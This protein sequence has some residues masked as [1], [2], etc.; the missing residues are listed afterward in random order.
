MK[1]M[2]QLDV[3]PYLS[4]IKSCLKHFGDFAPNDYIKPVEVDEELVNDFK[5]SHNRRETCRRYNISPA[6][7]YRIYNKYLEGR[8]KPDKPPRIRKKQ[9]SGPISI[10]QIQTGSWW[11]SM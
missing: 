9:P 11:R 7:A 4:E 8:L 5:R 3:G 2:D 6:T 1:Q 10:Q